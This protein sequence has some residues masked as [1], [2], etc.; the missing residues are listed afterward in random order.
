M[1][2]SH[3]SNA[4]SASRREISSRISSIGLAH[5]ATFRVYPIVQVQDYSWEHIFNT[6]RLIAQKVVNPGFRNPST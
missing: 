1:I 5:D 4:A 2:A 3:T 6:L